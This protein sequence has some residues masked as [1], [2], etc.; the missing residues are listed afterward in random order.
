M[1]QL[2]IFL[3]ISTVIIGINTGKDRQIITK[4]KWVSDLIAV[5]KRK[6]TYNN[7]YPYNLLYYDG[8]YWSA[9][10]V[11]IMKA[12]FNGRN[13]NDWTIKGFQRDLTNTGDITTE[14]MIEK[15]SSV[16]SNFKLLKEGEPRI[17]HLS[18]HIGGY[19]G[20]NV[21]INGAIYNVVEATG[22]F[23][24]KIAFSW[25]DNDGTRRDRKGGNLNGRWTRH[26]LPTRW[27]KY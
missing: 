9:D 5:A 11:N 17:L 18:G 22:S 26:G 27:V 2:L 19:L 3:L 24:R 12:L 21:I 8:T 13:I 20:K 14:Q 23:G 7:H 25:V 15:C 10:C 16:S 4:D 1:K 6:T